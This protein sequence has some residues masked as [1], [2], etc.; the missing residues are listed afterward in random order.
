MKAF[1]TYSRGSTSLGGRGSRNRRR[2]RVPAIAARRRRLAGTALSGQGN[3]V[4]V[5]VERKVLKRVRVSGGLG[6]VRLGELQALRVRVGVVLEDALADGLEVEDA[7]HQV[8][9]P[10]GVELARSHGVAEAAEALEGL[11]GRVREGADD[12]L[13]GCVLASPVATPTWFI[14]ESVPS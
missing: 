14:F 8:T 11:A 3:V 5:D 7:V 2:G 4:S 1:K 10:E 9:G 13:G 12:G 6:R